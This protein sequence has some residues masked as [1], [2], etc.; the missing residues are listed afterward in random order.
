VTSLTS[1][2]RPT[3]SQNL[4]IRRGI[5]TDWATPGQ[6]IPTPQALLKIHHKPRNYIP[7]AYGNKDFHAF[8]EGQGIM[9]HNS[10]HANYEIIQELLGWVVNGIGKYETNKGMS[11]ISNSSSLWFC[12]CH[13][14]FLTYTNTTFYISLVTITGSQWFLLWLSLG[15]RVHTHAPAPLFLAPLYSTS[16]WASAMHHRKW[17]C[18]ST[19]FLAPAGCG[20]RFAGFHSRVHLGQVTSWV[21]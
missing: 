12:C 19:Q 11:R 6:C 16:D 20:N 4:K 2:P 21:R 17:K 13:C 1:L 15:A 8:R 3:K 9:I 18:P 5:R 10:H 14:H 7:Q